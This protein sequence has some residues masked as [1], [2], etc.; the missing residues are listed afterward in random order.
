VTGGPAFI[1]CVGMCI[2]PGAVLVHAAKRRPRARSA[3][4][5][6]RPLARAAG[7]FGDLLGAWGRFP[8]GNG[9][10]LRA[11]TRAQRVRVVIS[12]TAGWKNA[13]EYSFMKAGRRAMAQDCAR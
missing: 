3:P 12:C 8:Q 4:R 11:E 5:E 6:A 9:G 13:Q 1:I 7:N 10:A 2:W